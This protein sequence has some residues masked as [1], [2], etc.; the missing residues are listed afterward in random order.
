MHTIRFTKEAL[1]DVEEAI[2]WYENHRIG[3]SYDFELCLEVGI[4]EISRNPD[5]FQLRYKNV[6]VRFI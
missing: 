1:L 6:K 2:R 5:N 4:A 3:L